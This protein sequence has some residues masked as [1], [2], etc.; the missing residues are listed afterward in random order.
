[1]SLTVP[2]TYLLNIKR[3]KQTEILLISAIIKFYVVKV[4]VK[5]KD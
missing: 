2:D 1:M 5:I 4:K 3:G